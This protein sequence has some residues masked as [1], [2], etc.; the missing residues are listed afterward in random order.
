M[1]ILKNMIIS[2]ILDLTESLSSKSI[3]DEVFRFT[4]A[5]RAKVKANFFVFIMVSSKFSRDILILMRFVILPDNIGVALFEIGS[6]L[7]AFEDI[8][9]ML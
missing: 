3:V 8:P 2:G 5:F 9:Y 4:K 6:C 7:E 1:E